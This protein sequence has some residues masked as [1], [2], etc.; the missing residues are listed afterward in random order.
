[1][2]WLKFLRIPSHSLKEERRP[3][4]QTACPPLMLMPTQARD[5]QVYDQHTILHQALEAWRTNPLARRLVGLTSQYVVGGGIRVQCAHP[6]TQ[7]FLDKWWRHELNQCALRVYEWCDELTRSGE[8]FFLLSSDAAGMSY[9]RAV[10]AAQ[11]GRVETTANDLQQETAFC[12]QLPGQLAVEKTWPAY[13]EHT[14]QPGADG[15]FPPVMFHF[16]INRPVGAVRGESDLAPLLRWLNRYAAW[17]EDRAR[18]NRFRNAFYFVVRAR[19]LNEGERAARQ[20]TLNSVPPTPGSILVT[21]ESEQWEVIHPRLESHEAAE[22]G[23]SLKKIIA[24]GAGVPLHFLAEPEG[25]TRTTA[26]AA[27]G[28]TFR[29][30]EQRQQFFCE[31]LRHLAQAAVRRRAHYDRRIDPQARIQVLG[32]D[33]SARDNASLAIATRSASQTFLDLYDRGLIG[34]Q[35]LLRVIY[36]FSGEVVDPQTLG[37]QPQRKAR[38]PRNPKPA[39]PG[40]NIAQ[41]IDPESGEPR[42]L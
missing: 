12:Q 27:G 11:I 41:V 39:Q 29:H 22:D 18:L 34:D 4:Q 14:D 5:R 23:L 6:A 1:M 15:C 8:L 3:M 40:V 19:F 36:R 10:P 35:E 31:L 17:L 9:L 7:A 24:A 32:A 2:N 28:P 25:S 26:E 30:F 42:L 33:L 13:Q 20:A 16:A 38:R 37:S 21:D